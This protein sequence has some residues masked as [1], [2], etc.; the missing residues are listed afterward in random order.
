MLAL[1]SLLTIAAPVVTLV[2]AGEVA[3]AG[4]EV[5]LADV[6]H[7]IDAEAGKLVIA[8]LPVGRAR[9][10]LD[11]R[12]VAMLVERA[13]PGAKVRGADAGTISL[14][15]P[16]RARVDGNCLELLTGLPAGQ[17]VTPADV[18]AADCG[19]SSEAALR[20]DPAT[21]GSI[22][23]AA[24]KAGDVIRGG[25]LAAAPQVR[26][27]QRL[28]LSARSGPVVIER[29]VTAMQ[30]ARPADRRIFVQTDDG[31]VFA[32]PVRAEAESHD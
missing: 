23:T 3:L 30:A 19:E 16:I 14:V 17:L 11:R 8:R 29:P 12:Q 9:I 10:R 25:L 31:Q 27:G 2:P 15:A 22:A 28:R 4:R 6:G 32:A 1:A 26:K 24:L 7:G 20:H 13:L 21:G 18:R 5:R